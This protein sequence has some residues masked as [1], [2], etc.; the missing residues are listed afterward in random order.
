[1]K[2]M[3]AHYDRFDKY[4]GVRRLHLDGHF[5]NEH[6]HGVPERLTVE[7][8]GSDLIEK[9]GPC[10]IR[11][12]LIMKAPSWWIR[13]RLLTGEHVEGYCNPRLQLCVL[14]VEQR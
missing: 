2:L 8:T 1:M 12:T 10:P 3:L 7:V 4:V 5:L 6:G 14:N 13:G 9:D 11:P